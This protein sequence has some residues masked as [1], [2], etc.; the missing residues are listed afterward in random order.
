MNSKKKNELQLDE[1]INSI[2]NKIPKLV[3]A[4]NLSQ[5]T[6][7]DIQKLAENF[8]EL[9]ADSKDMY[10]EQYKKLNE[11]KD[12]V[13]ELNKKNKLI[14]EE[15]NNLNKLKES[16]DYLNEEFE[17]KLKA[18]ENTESKLLE[19]EK[20][21]TEY[22]DSHYAKI[23]NSLRST[24]EKLEEKTI[25]NLDKITDEIENKLN[26]EMKMY[27]KEFLNTYEEK[28]VSLKDYITEFKNRFAKEIKETANSR[29]NEAIREFKNELRAYTDDN[30]NK[31]DAKIDGIVKN[32]IR[33][34]DLKI[35]ELD[36][37]IN[38]LERLKNEIPSL[39][40]KNI[41]DWLNKESENLV[42][43]I[44]EVLKE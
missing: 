31:F 1:L 42:K 27:E 38:L 12:T 16:I 5:K 6:V 32:K 37:T 19:I 3:E 4:I 23:I 22:I 44:V 17:E 18:F 29:T 28:C 11:T 34:V 25:T 41:K 13:D 2:E 24:F 26:T 14:D 10:K 40:E 8:N 21:K 9:L 43:R 36:K 35:E 7:F 33:Q 39:L 15:V 30:I 20:K